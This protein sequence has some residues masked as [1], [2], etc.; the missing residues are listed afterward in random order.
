MIKLD[1]KMASL[2]GNAIVTDTLKASAI[3]ANEL[4]HSRNGAGND[5]LGW[6]DLPT[7]IREEE[8]R[9]I[10]ATAKALRSKA[11][12]I[13]VIG[14]GGSYLGA[15]AVIETLSDRFEFLNKSAAR[16]QIVFA[17]H[18]ISGDYLHDLI[19]ATKT[20]SIAA[21]MI[22]KSGSTTESSIAFRFIRKEIEKRYGTDG[23][24]E[25]IVAV[26]D[27]S[28]GA[29]KEMATLA[30]YKTFVIPNNIGGR[31]SVLTP[32][33]LLPVAAA[34]ID[35]RA[36][37]GGARAMQQAT[38]TEV[39][40]EKNISAQY[41]AT[42]NALYNLG[43]KIEILG[44]YEPNMEYISKWWKQLFGESEGKQG[45]GIFPSTATFTTDLHSMGQY[46]QEGERTIFET[47]VSVA[48]P[49][50]DLTIA[51]DNDNIDKLN[52]LA[53]K[54]MHEIN[55]IAE[56]GVTLAHTDG[57]VPNIR[58]EIDRISEYE[59][60]GLIYFFEKACGISGYMLG[61]NPFDQPGVEA[62][63]NNIFAL[64]NKPGFEE[65]GESLHTRLKE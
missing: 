40:Y 33:G 30:G 11:D 12:V 64:L 10:E 65:E 42:R 17:G 2:K 24:R 34:G 13:I 50:D 58:V 62:Y 44:S 3:A 6:I 14:I 1:T 7:T 46:I 60:G 47:I 8:I 22:S 38:S 19:E 57:G 18:N 25:R 29:L 15:K 45:K 9:D 31:Y 51:A 56:L 54:T 35:I 41:A 28:N 32:V 27:R 4:L 36:L 21:I 26:T 59:I 48:N 20:L 61:I 39:P 5:L 49:A 55:R 52:Y 37:I 43:Y 16:P 63:K 23:A 53:G